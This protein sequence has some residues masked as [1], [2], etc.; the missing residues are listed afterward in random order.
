MAKKSTTNPHARPKRKSSHEQSDSGPER[1]M[2]ILYALL[3]LASFACGF[4]LIALWL[5]KADALA[6]LGLTGNFYY[7]VL[8]PLGVSVAGFLFG[9]MRSFGYYRGNQFGGSLELGGAVVGFALVVIG[10]FLLVKNPATFPLTVFVHAESGQQE[11]ALRNS[12]HVML[13]VPPERKREPI[14]D[15]GQ[16]YFPAIPANFRGQEV[17]V[18]LDAE[19]YELVNP[20]KRYRLEAGSIYLP[21]RR[22]SVQV[23]GRVQDE[24][25]NPVAGASLSIA[26]LS[27]KS[28]SNGQFEVTIPGSH[29]RKELTLL[30]VAEGYA[31]SHNAVV[32][33]SNEIVIIM[34]RK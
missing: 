12:G 5:W 2:I 31:P 11:L 19:G 21:I 24:V 26:G 20:G 27:C 3:S 16:A 33:S 28:D 30:A 17:A 6:R 18:L 23:F 4:V 10:G 14:G 29:V 34:K 13:D 15:K 32:P 1:T 7:V 22:K 9:A 8:L 25:G